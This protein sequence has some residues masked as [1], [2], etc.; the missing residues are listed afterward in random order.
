[1]DE[2]HVHAH[3]K[4]QSVV[5]TAAESLQEFISGF[6]MMWRPRGDNRHGDAGKNV[7]LPGLDRQ[8]AQLTSTDRETYK[9]IAGVKAATEQNSKSGN[10][11]VG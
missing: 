10:E 4:W 11:S 1:M 6:S 8:E 3:A 2:L 7:V 9:Y 5:Q